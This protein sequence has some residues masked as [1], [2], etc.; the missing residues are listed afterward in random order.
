L[1]CFFHFYYFFY[2]VYYAIKK[3]RCVRDSTRQHATGSEHSITI[4]RFHVSTQFQWHHYHYVGW[5]FWHVLQLASPAKGSLEHIAS[6]TLSP[7][8]FSFTLHRRN[9]RKAAF[10]GRPA[11]TSVRHENGAFQKRHLKGWN[12]RNFITSAS[13]FQ[14]YVKHFK[15][16]SFKKCWHHWF[17]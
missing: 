6:F 17:I 5:A 2:S 10:Y 13:P 8:Q 9:F 11:F 14:A 3:A 15:C 16:W 4:T 1:F 12:R 7:T